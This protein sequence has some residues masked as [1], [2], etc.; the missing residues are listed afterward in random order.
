M[1]CV[2]LICTPIFDSRRIASRTGN[3]KG[4][5]ILLHSVSPMPSP[6]ICGV[7]GKLNAPLGCSCIPRH[8]AG[9]LLRSWRD[10]RRDGLIPFLDVPVIY[11]NAIISIASCATRNILQI[12]CVI[13]G[14]F[15][16][17][18]ACLRENI[19]SI[20]VSL[21]KASNNKEGRFLKRTLLLC[22][23]SA[24]SKP[25]L[26]GFKSAR[27]PIAGRDPFSRSRGMTHPF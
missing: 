22:D 23:P 16:R 26:L 12:A 11:G 24:V 10:S 13:F 19:F 6:H 25:P 2:S 5:S 4:Q 18:R 27:R 21:P 8:G 15:Q 14:G 7:N 9:R 1:N 17:K 3:R 20:K